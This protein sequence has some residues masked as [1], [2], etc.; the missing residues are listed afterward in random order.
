MLRLRSFCLT[1]AALLAAALISVA[2]CSAADDAPPPR[3][4]DNPGADKLRML[5]AEKVQKELDLS[6][7]QRDSLKKISDD[8]KKA[9]EDMRD[10]SPEDGARR[11]ARRWKPCRR[12]P[13][14]CSTTSSASGSSRSACNCAARSWRLTRKKTLPKS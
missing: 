6:D 3:P 4:R 8:A 1:A 12:R 5:M 10:L 9:R 14:K 7:A 11:W 2:A 13:T